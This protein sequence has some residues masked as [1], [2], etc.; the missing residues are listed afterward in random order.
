MWVSRYFALRKYLLDG[1]TLPPWFEKH[2]RRS[3][4]IRVALSCV[5]WEGNKKAVE[6]VYREAKRRGLV[7]DHVI[8]LAHPYVC[9][10]TVPGNLQLLTD[11]VNAA[12]GNKW[13]PDQLDAWALQ[14]EPHQTSLQL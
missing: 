12:K 1:A 9:G 8:P 11:E 4:L 14:P 7:V 10:L 3:R 6:R 13:H 2:P 5:P